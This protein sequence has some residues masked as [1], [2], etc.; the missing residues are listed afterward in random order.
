MR[1]VLNSLTL[2]GMIIP[3]GLFITYAVHKDMVAMIII[4]LSFMIPLALNG[5]TRRILGLYEKPNTAS[6]NVY[7]SYLGVSQEI[8]NN[9]TMAEDIEPVIGLIGYKYAIIQQLPN[10]SFSY[11]SPS[12][13]TRFGYHD[14]CLCSKMK[15]IFDPNCTCGWYMFKHKKPAWEYSSGSPILQIRPLGRYLEYD[16]GYRAEQ[17]RVSA[18]IFGDCNRCNEPAEYGVVITATKQLQGVCNEHKDDYEQSFSFEE[19]EGLL[20]Q[21]MDSSKAPTRA[22]KNSSPIVSI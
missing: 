22:V 7:N 15:H 13:S 14:Y 11:V 3:T 9:V 16:K 17:Q 10:K 4:G 2:L 8:T 6:N 18:G 21:P 19:L 20:P 12:N 1:I 5:L